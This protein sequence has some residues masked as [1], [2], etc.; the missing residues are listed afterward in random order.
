[1]KPSSSSERQVSGI[2]TSFLLNSFPSSLLCVY[3]SSSSR[4]PLHWE[5]SLQNEC[6][7]LLHSLLAAV[8]IGVQLDFNLPVKFCL[9]ME[10]TLKLSPVLY[11]VIKIMVLLHL[12]V[13]WVYPEIVRPVADCHDWLYDQSHIATTGCTTSHSCLGVVRPLL[14]CPLQEEPGEYLHVHSLAL[15]QPLLL[16]LAVTSLPFP[17][18]SWAA[19]LQHCSVRKLKEYWYWRLIERL[20]VC[21]GRPVTRP[22]VKSCNWSWPV[23]TGRTTSRDVVRR[24]ARPIVRPVW[25]RPFVDR[26]DWWHDWSSDHIRPVCDLRWFGIAE[27]DRRLCCD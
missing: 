4:W 11:C 3:I 18:L 2:S 16:H 8:E 27:H 19:F 12:C 6:S 26:H 17:C 1:M 10:F 24:V 5:S 20:F 15:R 23:T 22:V 9:K 25:P 14:A 7:C 13:F 21:E